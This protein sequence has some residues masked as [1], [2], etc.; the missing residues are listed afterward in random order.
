MTP[1][2]TKEG[3]TPEKLLNKALW[4]AKAA[5]ITAFAAVPLAITACGMMHAH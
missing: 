1:G 4:L 2:T 3:L 5:L